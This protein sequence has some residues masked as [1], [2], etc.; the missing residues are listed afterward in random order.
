[1]FFELVAA[2]RQNM[3]GDL[4]RV[5]AAGKPDERLPV[6]LTELLDFAESVT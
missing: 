2:L 6:A 4:V 3:G 1:L 5:V